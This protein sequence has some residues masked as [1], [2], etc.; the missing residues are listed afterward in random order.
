VILWCIP[1]TRSPPFTES[2]RPDVRTH[3]L[4]FAGV[5]I[6]LV[7]AYVSA[8]AWM[9]AWANRMFREMRE[10]R[11]AA[12]DRMTEDASSAG[13]YGGRPDDYAAALKRA[14]KR[15]TRQDDS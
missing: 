7:A 5:L 12:L 6:G 14:R 15:H 3:P 2:I 1:S 4:L 8:A 11:T 9:G 13:I 10:E